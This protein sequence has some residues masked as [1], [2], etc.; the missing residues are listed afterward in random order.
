MLEHVAPTGAHQLEV[1]EVLE[2]RLEIAVEGGI[3]ERHVDAAS[4][5]PRGGESIAGD[6]V[7]VEAAAAGVLTQDAERRRSPLDQGDLPTAGGGFEADS[8]GAG[9]EV[10]EVPSGLEG[11]AVEERRTQ[12]RWRRPGAVWRCREGA[13]PGAAGEDAW[14]SH[15]P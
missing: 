6:D 1:D 4:Q 11:E 14:R 9:V 2:Q 5:T 15:G 13:P 3:D 12:A 10:E 8:A 7:R